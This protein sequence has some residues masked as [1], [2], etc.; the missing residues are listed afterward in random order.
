MNGTDGSDG[1][2]GDNDGFISVKQSGPCSMEQRRAV[3]VGCAGAWMAI[4]MEMEMK[5]RAKVVEV[6]GE[7]SRA[8]AGA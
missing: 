7:S 8:G 6:E 4:V 2:D 3:D 1:G 5:V